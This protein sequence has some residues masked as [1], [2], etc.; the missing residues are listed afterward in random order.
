[1]DGVIRHWPLEAPIWQVLAEADRAFA[2]RIINIQTVEI[3]SVIEQLSITEFDR[4]HFPGEPI[5]GQGLK[6]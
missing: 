2:I 3:A 4:D 6:I 5:D 1:M